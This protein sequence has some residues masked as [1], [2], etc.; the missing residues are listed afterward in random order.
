MEVTGVPSD[1]WRVEVEIGEE[2]GASLGER[3]SAIRLDEDAREEFAGRIV[4]TRDGTHLFAY[5]SSEAAARAAEAEIR[6]LVES[7]GLDAALTLTR[8]HPVEEAWK[9]AATPM[10]A[11]PD[12]EEAERKRHEAAERVEEEE[13][14]KTDWD[15]AVH[16]DSV[17]DMLELDRKLRDEGLPVERRWKY[18][19]VGASTEEQADELADRV[20]AL[21][22]EGSAVEVI[23]NPSDLPNPIFVA[24]GALA[25][26][27]RQ[28]Y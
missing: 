21:A 23:V 22:P 10:P 5:A 26:R 14:G 18:L 13:T 24:I 16:L 20:R 25:K 28:G 11:T 12:E 19:L 3:L 15:V 6:K 27:L 1:E 8:W 7:D 2:E 9:D 17:A 4:V